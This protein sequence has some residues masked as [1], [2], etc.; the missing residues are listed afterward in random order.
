MPNRTCE[1]CK[2]RGKV[3]HTNTFKCPRCKGSGFMFNIGSMPIRGSEPCKMC[4]GKGDI[5]QYYELRCDRCGGR[6]YYGENVPAVK[7]VIDALFQMLED[8]KH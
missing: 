5:T 7:F 4:C 3:E 8:G 6:G 2:G 1:V